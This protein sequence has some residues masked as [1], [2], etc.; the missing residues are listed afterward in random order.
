MIV[1][2]HKSPEGKKVIAVCDSNILGKKFEEKN[3]QLDL[4]SDFYYGSEMREDDLLR[5]IGKCPCCLNVVGK[6][7]VGFCIRNNFADKENMIKIKG[8]PHAQAV[9]TDA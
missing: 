4:K 3:M 7:S 1:K 9:I 2:I 8:I 5:E 6:N